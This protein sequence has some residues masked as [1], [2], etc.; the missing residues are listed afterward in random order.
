MLKFFTPLFALSLF[1]QSIN[2][3][4][5]MA[6]DQHSCKKSHHSVNAKKEWLEFGNDL[7]NLRNIKSKI[8]PDNVHKLKP[9][10]TFN[11]TYNMVANPAAVDDVLY[12]AEGAFFLPGIPTGQASAFAINAKTGE[13]IWKSPNL[14]SSFY[15]TPA[16][17]TEKTFFP[18]VG[19]K[20]RPLYI[21]DGGFDTLEAIVIALDRENGQVLWS[22]DVQQES[23]QWIAGG[24]VL[25][26]EEDLLFVCTAGFFDDTISEQWGTIVALRASTGDILWTYRTTRGTTP[27]LPN[28]GGSSG[29][30]IFGT[31]AVDTKSGL[32]F[33]GTGQSN[34]PPAS[35]LTDSLLALN[36]R[37]TN[38][39]GEL[40]WHYQFTSDD[41]GKWPPGDC[42]YSDSTVKDW[43]ASCGPFLLEVEH[44]K[45]HAL[46]KI[47]IIGTKEGNL[48]ALDRKK[49]TLIWKTVVTN[50]PPTGSLNSGFQGFACSDGKNIYGSAIY[51]LTGLPIFSPTTIASAIVAIRG[52]D[53]QLLWRQDING[54]TF[55]AMTF[56][57]GVVYQN[58]V[59]EK[60]PPGDASAPNI[61]AKLRAFSAKDGKVLFEHDNV[62]SS[63]PNFNR[64][65]GATT[66]YKNK[67]Y[68]SFGA[69]S[70]GITVGPSG[71]QAFEVR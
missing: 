24:P 23:E 59:G 66:V 6:R 9:A 22:K 13:Q 5:C 18:S 8:N 29:A 56:S 15:S 62:V 48:Y 2:P 20:V 42:F 69:A 30:G 3:S 14:G 10:W 43:D 7:A 17:G 70:G 35:P 11:T 52:S 67:L 25:V 37:T 50:P 31:P 40:V 39:E 64:S 32:L 49:G 4:L 55:N 27:G 63:D 57:N 54:G 38:P 61:G 47:V 26:Q 16:V 51:I 45:R 65:L 44:G 28:F 1:I 68:F 71:I 58:T 41:A 53:G 46:R 21:C 12:F 34:V 19:R 33:I 60:N 36:Y